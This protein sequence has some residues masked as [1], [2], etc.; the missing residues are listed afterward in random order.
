MNAPGTWYNA[1]SLYVYPLQLRR[2]EKV[3][4]DVNVVCTIR[5]GSSYV[6][7]FLQAKRPGFH[8]PEI[9][10]LSLSTTRPLLCDDSVMESTTRRFKTCG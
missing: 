9:C 2:L 3:E 8:F 1:G 6:Y 7:E 10:P 4:V 5:I